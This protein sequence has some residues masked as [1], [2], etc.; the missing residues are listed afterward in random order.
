MSN[1][2]SWI[3]LFSCTLT[4]VFTFQETKAQDRYV[5][6]NTPL[7]DVIHDIESRG[8]I[9]FLYRDALVSGKEITIDTSYD[10]LVPS[11]ED[12]LRS[13][14][15]QVLYDPTHQ[16]ILLS[17][18]KRTQQTFTSILS[19]HV[20]DHDTGGRLPFANVTWVRDGYLQ[21]VTTNESGFFQYQF[22][23]IEADQSDII[24]SISYVGY[25]SK[26]VM[27]DL[28]NLPSELSIRLKTATIEGNEVLISSSLLSTNLDTTWHH[29][30]NPTLFSPFGESSV[31]RSLSGLP[32]VTVSTALSDGLNVRGSKT[33]G[34]QVL[35]DGAPIYNQNHFFGLF[36]AFNADALQ[37][38]GFYYDIAP[39]SYF[40]PPGGTLSF[41]T[42]A[43]S[44]S[45][46]RATLA[47]SNTSI[48]TTIEGPIS[49]GKLSF[50]VSGRHSYLDQVSWFNN[51]NLVALGLNSEREISEIPPSLQSVEEVQI[52]PLESEARFFDV[53]AKVTGETQ[54]GLRTTVSVYAGGNQTDLLTERISLERNENTNR[55]ETDATKNRTFNKWGNETLSIQLHHRLGERGYMQTT[56]AA[57]HYLSRYQKDDFVYTRYNRNDEPR[58]FVFPF[59]HQNELFNAKIA[60]DLTIM[61]PQGG[62]WSLGGA[63]N[64]YAITYLEQSATR[65]EFGEDY[66]AIQSDIYGEYEQ[67]TNVLD[68]R[69]GLRGIHFTQGQVVRLSPRLQTTIWPKGWLSFRAGYSKNYQFLHQLYLE[70][71]NSPGIWI[72]TTG[73]QGPSSVDNYT[74]GVYAKVFTHALLQVEGY[75][76]TYDKLRR[77]EINAPTQ[78]TTSNLDSFVPWFSE[79]SGRAKG[80]EVLYRQHLGALLWTNSYTLSSID[81]RN[82]ELLNGDWFPAEWD[83]RHQATSTVQIP[84]GRFFSAQLSCFFA[85]GS[86]DIFTYS[87][88][89]PPERLP[90]YYR[91]D[92]S[93]QYQYSFHRSL[94]KLNFSIYNILDKNNTWYREKLQVFNPRRPLQGTDFLT[95]DVFDLGIQPSFDV[96]ITF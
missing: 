13:Q 20:V 5:Y 40:A 82:N 64:Y 48:R 52:T 9:R 83:H 87:V 17:Q 15:V 4:F 55:L 16:L 69:L 95:V 88:D 6:S 32:A 33:D 80:I 2:P 60:Q 44:L 22:E 10:E 76:R 71:T 47:A 84:L 35:L 21:G 61:S 89:S 53:H 96:S 38:V 78:V 7:Q 3:L 73:S 14:Q 24:L 37:T 8:S 12:V 18:S 63:F 66:Y 81:L 58:N 57:S 27:V 46:F 41:I 79:N 29:L 68:I 70:N 39:A 1:F 62:L 36:D 65:P 59:E 92:T 72:L 49:K 28:A 56:A 31:I 74:A 26:Q 75:Y 42:R 23:E 30:L 25:H 51:K 67:K 77:H 11:L 34:F 86:P 54:A 50:L 90:N 85:S 45:N 43:G 94:I 19:G 91:L 93:V